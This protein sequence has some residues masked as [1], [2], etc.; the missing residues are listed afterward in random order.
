MS[1]TG[2]ISKNGIEYQLNCMEISLVVVSSMNQISSK[3]L[4][5]HR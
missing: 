2:S 3:F 4:I 1:D 5:V